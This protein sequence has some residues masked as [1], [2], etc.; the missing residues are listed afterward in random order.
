MALMSR[1]AMVSFARPEPVSVVAEICQSFTIDN[2]AFSAWKS[3]KEF[4]IESYAEFIR[5]WCHH[6]AFDWY[7]IPDVIDGDAN[8]N[9]KMRGAWGKYCQGTDMWEMGVPV[10]H[11]HEPLEVLTDMAHAYARVAIGSSGEFADVGTRPWWERMTE[12]MEVVTDEKGHPKAK[13]HGLR[14]LDPTIFSQFPFASADSTNVARNIGIDNSWKGTYPPSSKY[15]RA[16]VMMERIEKHAS[17][18]RWC[19]SKGVA[20]NLDLFG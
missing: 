11:L 1:H 15:T 13:L 6:P 12:A 8:D 19:G 5:D 10:W 20:K 9:I 18:A 16:L 17:A 2:G 7:I 14:M 3:G 4:D